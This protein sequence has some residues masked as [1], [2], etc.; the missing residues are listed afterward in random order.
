MMKIGNGFRVAI[1]ISIVALLLFPA[2]GCP[3]KHPIFHL[4]P[5]SLLFSPAPQDGAPPPDQILTM[6]GIKE[7]PVQGATWTLE[8]DQPWLTV[9]PNSGTLHANEAIDLT[10]HADQTILPLP[11]GLQMGQ[12]HIIAHYGRHTYPQTL[13]VTLDVTPGSSPP[14]IVNP[15]E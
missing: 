1:R 12:I 7:I 8:T 4:S 10:V 15:E 5:L 6:T 9:T 2:V 3:R 11:V 13:D 14:P